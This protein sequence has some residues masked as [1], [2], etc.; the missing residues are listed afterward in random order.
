[1]DSRIATA[2]KVPVPP[3]ATLLVD[4]AP[5]G[6]MQFTPGRWGC[7]MWLAAAAFKGRTAVAD[8]QTFGCLG[9]GTGLGF[10]NQYLNWPGGVECFHRFLADGND[11]WAHGREVAEQIRGTMRPESFEHFVHGERYLKDPDVTREFLASLPVTRIDR[12]YVVFLPL[13][14]LDT[15][16]PAPLAVHFLVDADRLAALVAL[17]NHRG[18]ASGSVAVPWGAGCQS[19]GIHVMKAATRTPPHAVLG[20]VDL[21]V[22]DH[23][24]RQFGRGLLT[25]SIPFAMFQ[26]ME[27]DVQGSFLELPAWQ[28][29]IG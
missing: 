18:A 1:M 10:G 8:E 9:G 5:E 2:L 6:A 17:A 12:R 22:R 14:D 20:L 16:A 7:V 25:F 4:E 28:K 3:I 21:A 24:N 26:R 13:A 27:E 29:L 11:G 19:L 23:F 15:R